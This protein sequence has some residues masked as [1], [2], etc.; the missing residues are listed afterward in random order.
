MQTPTRVSVRFLGIATVFFFTACTFPQQPMT[1]QKHWQQTSP[2]RLPNFSADGRLAVKQ[3]RKGSHAHFSWDRRGTIQHMEIKSPF[4]AVLG[5]LCRDDDGVVFRDDKKRIFQAASA[6]ALTRRLTGSSFPFES[7]EAW[8]SGSYFPEE[9]HSILPDG[10]LQQGGWLIDR[11]A[12]EDGKSTTKLSLSKDDVTIRMIF[13]RFE[14]N[15]EDTE[16]EKKC[17]QRIAE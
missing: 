17:L 3:G 4:G 7:L 8:V 10:Q 16:A 6:D 11:E 15:T 14:K 5:I 13:D 9:P 12:A 1:P 2:D